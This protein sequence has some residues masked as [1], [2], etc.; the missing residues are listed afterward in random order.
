MLLFD[1]IIFC[2]FCYN[3]CIFNKVIITD[4]GALLTFGWGL[5]GQVRYMKFSHVDLLFWYQMI[6]SYFNLA[7]VFLSSAGMV[8]QMMNLVQNVYRLFWVYR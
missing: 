1:L 2:N 5:H 7:S 3:H 6:D 8:A 4:T